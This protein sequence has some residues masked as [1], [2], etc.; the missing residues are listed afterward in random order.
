MSEWYENGLQFACTQCGNCCTGLPGDVWF[1]DAE[2]KAMADARGM[3]IAEFRRQFA[4]REGIRWSLTEVDRGGK[5]D[6]VFLDR[7]ADGLAICGVY[8]A[9]PSQ[10][11]TWPFWKQNLRSPESWDAVKRATPCR[12]M[13]AGSLIPIDAIRILRDTP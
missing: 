1:T 3:G 12:G 2:G 13:D 6:C 9:R 7:D 11:R 4:R 5:F 8:D 10:C